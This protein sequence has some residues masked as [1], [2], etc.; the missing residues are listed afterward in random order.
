MTAFVS[1]NERI[2]V[3]VNVTEVFGKGLQHRVGIYVPGTQDV[4][5]VLDKQTAEE[6]VDRVGQT[7]S[8]LFG[9]ASAVSLTG[10]YTAESG[11]L[12]RE[13]TTL[14]YAFCEAIA[15][16][17]LLQVRALALD[18]KQELG[19]ESIAVQVDNELF[20]V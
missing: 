11:S 8:S 19:Q 17:Q 20:F 15:T 13:N 9:G 18:L 16:E 5:K 14:V 3:V 10:F 2:N 12:V 7:F 4:D 6:T 1:S